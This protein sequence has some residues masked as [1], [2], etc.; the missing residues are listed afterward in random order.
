MVGGAVV[1]SVCCEA[2]VLIGGVAAHGGAAVDSWCNC[3]RG[4]GLYA[5]PSGM[6]TTRGED[7]ISTV[8]YPGWSRS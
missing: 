3:A 8:E 2:G 1:V 6:A 4:V 7:F 5:R